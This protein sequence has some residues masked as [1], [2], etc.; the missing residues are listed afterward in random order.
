MSVLRRHWSV[1]AADDRPLTTNTVCNLRHYLLSEES[2]DVALD[3]LLPSS[4]DFQTNRPEIHTMY[5]A[6]DLRSDTLTQPSAEM[7]R[8]IAEA[9]IGD[10]VFGEDPSVNALQE[11]AAQLLGKEAAIF[12]CSGT[13]GNQ[14]AIRAQTQHG[15]E[16]IAEKDSHTINFEAGGVAALSGVLVNTLEGK[17]GILRVEQI[18]EAMRPK[19]HH[20]APTRLICLENT[21]NRGGGS[22]YPLEEIVRIRDLAEETGLRMH[23]DGA[24]LFNASVASGVEP[25]EYA[26]YFDSVSFCLSK[27]LGCPVG[28]VVGGSAELIDTVHRFRK[29]FGGGMR[30]AGILAAA[31]LYA[32]KH[33][34][35]RL[36]EDHDTAKTLARALHSIE[37]VSINPD[38]VETNIVI[39]EVA[40]TGR[41]AQIITDLLKERGVLV[42][43]ISQTRIRAVTHLDVSRPDIEQA[44]EVLKEVLS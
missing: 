43:P 26:R 34:I 29:M 35:A 37:G 24:R 32:L 2:S 19:D 25:R 18:K 10:D 8:A 38:E 33:N 13:M 22:V 36:K 14:L 1:A 21:H 15:D 44:I 27:G 20:F 42:F 6:I 7:R 12:V 3:T 16:I 9:E 31:G 11:K 5:E 28:S 17:R 41:D 30:Q 4:I 39:F 23:L 40:E